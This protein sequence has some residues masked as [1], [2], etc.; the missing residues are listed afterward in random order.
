LTALAFR[1]RKPTAPVVRENGMNVDRSAIGETA[2]LW[3]FGPAEF[4]ESRREL[5]V[6]GQPVAIEAKPLAVLA[7]LLRHAGEVASQEALLAAAWPGVTVVPG[8]LTTAIAKLR[9]A[10]GPES[11]AIVVSVPR[12]G[13]RIGV[14]I[15]L[16]RVVD[17]ARL[18]GA[19][20]AGD[21]VPNRPQWRLARPLG[22]RPEPDVWLATHEKTGEPRVFKFADSAS[23]LDSLRREAALARLMRRALGDHPQ[24]VPILEWNFD[25]RPFFVESPFGGPDLPGWAASRGG[26]DTIPLP[27]RIAIVADIAAVVAQAHAIGVLHGDIKPANILVDD[28]ENGDR[29]VRLVDFGA[30]RLIGTALE[31]A[32]EISGLTL[33]GE[34]AAALG[35]RSGTLGYM[36]PELLAGA[37]PST[38]A[39]IYALGVLLYQLVAARLDASLAVGWEASVPDPLLRADIAEA[40]MGDPAQRL[41][42][43]SRPRASIAVL[44]VPRRPPAR[45]CIRRWA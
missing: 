18:A 10:L 41:A 4:D 30:G 11:R 7:E 29:T 12:L 6:N 2:R 21:P 20:A 34:E 40:A 33:A 26:I 15:R 28:Q 14:P 43:S 36:A 23:R 13:Y 32:R 1:E 19:L 24:L 27:E 25:T 42:S 44:P 39:D 31:Q 8:S 22:T 38:G 9:A 5:R 37:S 35:A 16:A 45:R 17:R 3:Q